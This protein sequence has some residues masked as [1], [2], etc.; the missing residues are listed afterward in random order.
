MDPV[1][2]DDRKLALE[3]LKRFGGEVDDFFKL[4]PPDKHYFFSDD[5]LSFLAYD[6]SHKTA[7]CLF[8]PVGYPESI[9]IL[10]KGFQR[11]CAQNGWTIALIQATG[12]YEDI[13]KR[14][15]FQKIV[16]GSDAVISTE[17]FNG[18]TAHNKYFRNL[19][20]RINKHGYKLSISKP[21]HPKNL[22]DKLQT[23]SDDWMELPDHKEWRFLTGRFD[24][25]YL[26][27]VPI[28][29]LSDNNERLLAFAN[30]LPLFKE[31]VATVDLMRRRRDTPPNTMDFLFI[32]LLAEL[33]RQNVKSFNLGLSPLDG[34][35]FTTNGVDKTL[36]RAFGVFQSFIGFRGL[37]QFKAK[38]GPDWE[39]R[40]VWF[41]GSLLRLMR[42]ALAVSELM[43]D[44]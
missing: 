11:Y 39:P 12:K 34:R 32:L 37:H 27:R 29:T 2:E 20:N 16:I 23:V 6:V 19:V 7:V 8:D 9:P 31:G 28:Y 1:S 41:D 3:L 18:T 21:P 25:D 15:G 4:W 33:K 42:V 30:G 38:Y 22:I 24:E 35:E 14:M 17:R 26:Q 40:Y 44:H 43:K 13:F 10:M 5:K 36:N